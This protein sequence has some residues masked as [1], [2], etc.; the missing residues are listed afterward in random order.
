MAELEPVKFRIDRVPAEVTYPLR[1]QVLRPHEPI[2]ALRLRGDDDPTTGT[3]AALDTDGEVVGTATV[4]Q[5]ACPW[6]PDEP[7]AW[8][9]RGMA[10][11]DSM[12]GQ[13]IGAHVLR[14]TIAHVVLEGGHLIWCNARTP[15][16]RFYQREGFV[17]EGDEWEDPQIGP[18]VAMWRPVELPED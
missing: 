14:A 9:L 7:A 1:Q 4:R 3:F 5:E 18:H 11:A 15:A 13:G 16:Q 10:T 17:V 12:R 2:S 6:R 8:R